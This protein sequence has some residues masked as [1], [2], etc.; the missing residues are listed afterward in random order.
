M[1]K[2]SKHLLLYFL[3]IA[4]V[5]AVCVMLFRQT[6][7]TIKYSDIVSGFKSGDVAEFEIDRHN[8]IN[9][10]FKEGTASYTKWGESASY[11]LASLEIFHRRHAYR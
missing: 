7:E 2:N 9:L 4:V 5:I 1:K 10:V 8:V 11:R 6:A 3:L